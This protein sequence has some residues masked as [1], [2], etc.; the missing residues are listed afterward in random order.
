MNNLRRKQIEKLNEQLHDIQSSLE[1]TKDDEQRYF[2]FIPENL[3]ESERYVSS[4]E[5]ID[6]LDNAINSIE[7]SITNLETILQ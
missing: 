1:E 3:Q 4:G 5:A 2:D 6:D 7:D